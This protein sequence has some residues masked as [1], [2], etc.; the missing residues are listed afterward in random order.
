MSD[1][2]RAKVAP[3]GT[4]HLVDGRPVYDVRFLSVLKF[5]APGLAPVRGNDGAWHIDIDGRPAYAPRHLRT[6]GFYE[7]RAAVEGASGWFHILPDGSPV[8]AARYAWCGNFQEQRCVVRDFSGGYFH[9]SRVGAEAYAARH[10]YA[11]DFR[12]GAA[13]VR[14]RDDGLCGHIDPSGRDLHTSRFLD[15]D[16]YHKGYARARDANGWFHVD[17]DGRP[18]YARRFLDVE[19][20]YNGA[21]LAWTNAGACAL[22]DEHG[23]VCHE[24][25][26]IRRRAAASEPRL[27]VLVLGNIGSGKSS[28]IA[29]LAP[30]RSWRA[31][32]IDDCR[33]AHGDGSPVGELRAWAAFVATAGA[34]GPSFFEC[35]GVG[36]QIPLLRLALRDSGDRVGVLWLRAPVDVCRSRLAQRSTSPPYPDFG[37]TAVET[38]SDLEQPLA[39]AMSPG[40]VWHKDVIGELDGTRAPDEVGAEAEGMIDAWERRAP[41]CGI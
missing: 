33:R 10:L 17:R 7:D 5:H 2:R 31:A 36:P 22:I 38:V 41:T 37:S 30:R 11:G 18:A 25:V 16:V 29:A 15:L 1:W 6:F 26:G 21:A 3:D 28:L 35:T 20:F 32:S 27:K 12:D 8:Y 9:I 39:R 14:R 4:H 19:P 40:G 23:N 13:V 24:V 34:P